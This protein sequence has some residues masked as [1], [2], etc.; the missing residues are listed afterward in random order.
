MLRKMR[1]DKKLYHGLQQGNTTFTL[2][3]QNVVNSILES[4]QSQK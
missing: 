4:N 2:N 3:K 1:Q